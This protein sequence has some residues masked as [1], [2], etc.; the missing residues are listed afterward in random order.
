MPKLALAGLVCATLALSAEPEVEKWPQFRGLDGRGVG[1]DQ[2]ALPSEFGPGKALLWKTDLPFG[3]GSPCVWGER[4]FVTAIDRENQRLEVIALNRK[5]GKVVWRQTVPAKEIEK[6]H[7]VSSAATRLRLRTETGFTSTSAPTGF[8][9]TS[10]MASSPGS[11]QWTWQNRHM[12][13]G[14]RLC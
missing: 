10:G 3:H 7:E 6:V 4:I 1:N 9:R 12:G 2:V 14:H 5:D 11:T 8:L 13:A